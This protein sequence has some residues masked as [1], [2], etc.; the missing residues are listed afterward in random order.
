MY[1]GIYIESGG[2][3]ENFLDLTICILFIPAPK[4]DYATE[5]PGRLKTRLL[6][7]NSVS[8]LVGLG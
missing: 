3:G 5:L 2:G 7:L 6:G 1:T 8:D 4:L